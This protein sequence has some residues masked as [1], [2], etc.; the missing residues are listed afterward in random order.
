MFP[1]TLRL[2]IHII[3]QLTKGELI[4]NTNGIL[5]R[6]TL[7]ARDGKA[8]I[9][10]IAACWLCYWLFVTG[11]LGKE[12]GLLICCFDARGPGR[13][14]A[15]G[16]PGHTNEPLALHPG[17]FIAE[18]KHILFLPVYLLLWRWITL[19]GLFACFTI[20]PIPTRRVRL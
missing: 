11:R 2:H 17:H 12:P 3:Y 13:T 5:V 8:R 16:L 4:L 9:A 6:F 14:L 18:S 20:A 1:Y 19:H 7:L 15:L 10:W